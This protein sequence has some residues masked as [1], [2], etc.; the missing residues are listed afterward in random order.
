MSVTF[1]YY[2]HL[3]RQGA[4]V[5][6]EQVRDIHVSGHA[7]K[8]ELKLLINTVRP[9]FFIPIHGEYRHLVKHRQLAMD[10]GM[11]PEHCLLLENGHV[12]ELAGEQAQLG[13]RVETEGFSWTARCGGCW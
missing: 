10:T 7:Y 3:Y 11:D 2:H 6:Y 1:K 5:I 4:E 8:E 9:R 13:G 12:L